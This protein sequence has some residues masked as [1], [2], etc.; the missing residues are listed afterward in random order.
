MSGAPVLFTVADSALV[1]TEFEGSL[2]MTISVA[3]GDGIALGEIFCN[4]M[5]SV[6]L[7]N[8]GVLANSSM[9][10]TTLTVGTVTSGTPAAGQTVWTEDGT[11]TEGTPKIQ[12]GFGPYTIA[13]AQTVEVGPT[14]LIL[15]E[16]VTV[17]GDA[18][19][20]SDCYEG[21]PTNSDS[22]ADSR[23]SVTVDGVVQNPGRDGADG[24]WTWIVSQGSTI[25]YNLNIAL[26]NVA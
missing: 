14:T 15:R 9:S 24:T 6:Q 5:N 4:Y 7:G 13:P 19:T 20:F 2:P 3:T 12:Y 26:G 16:F 1:P 18:V 17:P 10:N 23:S 22:S 25:A 8:V 11:G 21:V